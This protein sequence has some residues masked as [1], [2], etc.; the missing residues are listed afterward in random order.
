MFTAEFDVLRDEGVA[1]ANRLGKAG[2]PTHVR[3]FPGQLHVLCALP[4]EASEWKQMNDD[5]KRFMKRDL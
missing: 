5:I 2:V 3:C 1:Y 4:P